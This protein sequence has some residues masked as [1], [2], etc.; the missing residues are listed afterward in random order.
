M[1]MRGSA[2]IAC[3]LLAWACGSSINMKGDARDDPS[4]DVVD[5][6]VGDPITLSGLMFTTRNVGDRT[7]YAPTAS[8]LI[9]EIPMSRDL[10]GGWEPMTVWRPLDVAIECPAD[11]TD[12]ECPTPTESTQLRQSPPGEE[13]VVG[14]GPSPS[15]DACY[16]WDEGFCADC[17]CYRESHIYAGTY[18]ATRCVWTEV[19]CLETEPCG[20]E[21]V[22]YFRPAVGSGEELCFTTEFEIPGTSDVLIEIE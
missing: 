14:W 2:I 21:S 12:C 8:R 16:V 22:G 6:E 15:S 10:G 9:N 4:V 20:P 7:L 11:P 5:V 19:E 3:A 1:K 18:S 17:R 13:Y